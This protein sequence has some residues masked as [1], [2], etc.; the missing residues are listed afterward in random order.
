MFCWEKV[1][2]SQTVVCGRGRL[3]MSHFGKAIEAALKWKMQCFL[4]TSVS[5]TFPNLTFLSHLQTNYSLP[6]TVHT[7][8]KKSSK[9]KESLPIKHRPTN[10]L[11]LFHARVGKGTLEFCG[12]IYIFLILEL[13]Y[14]M[15]CKD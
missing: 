5:K 15:I 4:Q 9:E 8:T 14:P 10:T 1:A 13:L 12:T 3:M 6:K 7:L 11:P 2:F